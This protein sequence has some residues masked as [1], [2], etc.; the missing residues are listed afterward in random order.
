MKT[1]KKMKTSEE[2]VMKNPKSS[3]KKTGV[4]KLEVKEFHFLKYKKFSHS[5]NSTSY[6]L[7][8][9]NRK[10]L[11]GFPFLNYKKKLENYE[12]K[13]YIHILESIYKNGKNY[14]I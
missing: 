4:F 6:F 3:P 10:D 2:T 9:E 8:H 1:R 13:K 11:R 5:S 7:K 12:F 14:K